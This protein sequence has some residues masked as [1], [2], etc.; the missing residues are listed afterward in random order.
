M[1]GIFK[2]GRINKLSPTHSEMLSDS[3][4]LMNIV[5][6][7]DAKNLLSNEEFYDYMSV[8]NDI[9]Q[10]TKE[11]PANS[12]Q[13]QHRAFAIA[14]EFE[15]KAGISYE[16]ICGDSKDI[17]YLYANLLPRFEMDK[18]DMINA[19]KSIIDSMILKNGCKELMVYA[20]A[21]SYFY[22]VT[23][24]IIGANH[25]LKENEITFFLY[26]TATTDFNN[27]VIEK[28]E[29]AG[30]GNKSDERDGCF[31]RM[32][33][34]H[35]QAYDNCDTLDGYIETLT[36]SFAYL[37]GAQADEENISKLISLANQ[38]RKV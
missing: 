24:I 6:T 8:F 17:L 15:R 3:M 25:E 36:R 26:Q 18:E 11:R 33:E 21:Y 12:L 10:R 13:Y 35:R 38:W 9:K 37:S 29:A 23:A 31:K 20:Y 4:I 5:S 1:F 16:K 2:M 22:H 19:F 7:M 34:M 30:L 32:A 28:Y 14:Y 27:I